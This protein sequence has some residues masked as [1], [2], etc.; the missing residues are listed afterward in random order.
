MARRRSIPPYRQIPSSPHDSTI[1]GRTFSRILPIHAT[2]LHFLVIVK[3]AC[4]AEGIR[5]LRGRRRTIDLHA[6]DAVL[7]ELLAWAKVASIN[8]WS[9]L[10]I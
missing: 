9:S 8:R 5:L 4:A 2:H 10:W 3:R 6:T 1:L 7:E